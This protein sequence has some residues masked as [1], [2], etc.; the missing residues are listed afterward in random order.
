VVNAGG[1]SV[2]ILYASPTQLNIQI[3]YEASAGSVALTVT[4]G[5]VAAGNK[6]LSLSALAPGLFLLPQGTAAALN[7]DGSVNSQTRPAS[8]GSIVSAYLTG[9][10]P[11]NPSIATGAAAPAAPLSYVSATVTATI[12]NVNA[13]VTFAGLA[14]GFTGL[15]QVNIVVPQIAAGQY[16]L[17][18]AANGVLSNSALISVQ[19]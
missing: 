6:T 10:G 11:V 14:P 1:L 17:Q 8:V 18:V 15:Y 5:G 13:S 3:P 7:Q 2:P 16:P 19:D 12:G 9:L 4:A